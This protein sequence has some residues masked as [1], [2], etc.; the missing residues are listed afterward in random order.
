MSSLS[1]KSLFL[2]AVVCAGT[3]LFSGISCSSADA[4][5]TI[6]AMGDSTTAGTPRF[7]SPV[8]APPDG[9]GDE[10]SQYT[11]WAGKRYPQWLLLNRGVNGER[12]DQILRRLKSDLSA[13]HPQIVIVLAG[14]NDLYQ[15]YSPES[16]QRNLEAIYRHASR[17]G[18]RVMACTI[19]PYNGASPSVLAGMQQVNQWIQKS[20]SE[21]GFGFC[22]LYSVMQ[23]PFR[24]GNLI[25]TE[26]GFHPDVK[27]YRRMGE[28]VADCL[29]R[30]LSGS[31][32]EEDR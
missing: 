18:V 7:R 8:E 9:S 14:V 6:L 5:I 4:Q 26:D 17:E 16:V 12:S 2:A 21:S 22:D 24:A 29:Q 15:G 3:L 31:P 27:G 13:L 1:A 23:D 30:W 32:V 28:A 25:S 19:L 10:R 11:Y 20:C